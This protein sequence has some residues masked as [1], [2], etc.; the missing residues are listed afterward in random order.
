MKLEMD[1][2]VPSLPYNE[3]A[4]AASN[5]EVTPYVGNTSVF[6]VKEGVWSGMFA[7][8]VVEGCW[9]EDGEGATVGEFVV[10]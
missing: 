4:A 7:T 6:P 5:Q 8:L 9:E 3:T 2:V 1:N 10:S